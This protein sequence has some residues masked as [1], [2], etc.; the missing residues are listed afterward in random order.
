LHG[1]H[2]PPTTGPG[3]QGDAR[4]LGGIDTQDRGY[5]AGARAGLPFAIA[6]VVL[7]V[8]FGVLAR[9]LGPRAT[10]V[11]ALLAPALLLRA[12]V[13]LVLAVAVATTALLRLLGG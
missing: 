12:P 4:R 6:T 1:D 3:Y 7:G 2:L 5:G 11:I 13:L 9:Q 8:S 10:A